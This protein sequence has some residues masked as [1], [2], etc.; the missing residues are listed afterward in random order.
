MKPVP[1]WG[2]SLPTY[3]FLQIYIGLVCMKSKPWRR[4][5]QRSNAL[6]GIF[7]VGWKLTRSERVFVLEIQKGGESANKSIVHWISCLG[8]LSVY[9]LYLFRSVTTH[10]NLFARLEWFSV[11]AI[12]QIMMD[13]TKSV[14]NISPALRPRRKDENSLWFEKW[15][16]F[17]CA[18]KLHN[19]RSLYH[20]AN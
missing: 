1:A 2:Q 7:S 16:K 15:S 20:L 4:V 9:A 17:K 6:G 18:V 14:R 5:C 10:W 12:A 11:K 19:V 8:F 3:L 13:S